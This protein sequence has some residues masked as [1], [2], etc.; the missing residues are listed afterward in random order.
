MNN[1]GWIEGACDGLLS[2][3]EI[4]FVL[5]FPNEKKISG[6]INQIQ[7]YGFN[8][9]VESSFEEILAKEKPDLIHIFGTEY[10]HSL[11][12]TEVC[13]KMGY[14]DKIILNIQG[15]VHYIGKYH[16]YAGLPQH[17]INHWT[18]R[19]RIKRSNI[20]KQKESFEKRG[21]DE[22]QTIENV[23]HIIGR[24]DWDKACTEQINPNAQYHFCN[25][26]LRNEFYLHRW[27]LNSCEKHSIFLSQCSYPIKGFHLMLEAMPEILKRYPK[28]HI[29]TTGQNPLNLR[30]IDKVKQGSYSYYLGKLIKKH[31]L[32]DK[33]TFLGS[34]GEV[35]MCQRFLKSHVFV[36]ASTIENESN[37]ISEA[38]I[39][40]VPVVSSFVGG[41]TNRIEH[42]V[43]GLLYQHD[44]PYM[45]S[46][47]VCEIFQED[48][49]ALQFSENGRKKA[50]ITHDKKNNLD[51]LF[52]IYREV[53]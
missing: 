37:S 15:L 51:R 21:K 3:G 10:H 47:Y 29:Y 49:L 11:L 2:T 1:G 50:R 30:G 36:S 33:V 46:H 48:S 28:A 32:L 26:T 34:L 38:T 17:V 31:S 42:K 5:L 24:T 53:T 23:K 19:D 13:R 41:V 12:M 20:K 40:G 9:E 25:E 7:Y 35:E 8:N 27:N 16:Y 39:L 52:G 6:K 45:I 44:A 14:A 22:L 18:L 43:D 4:E